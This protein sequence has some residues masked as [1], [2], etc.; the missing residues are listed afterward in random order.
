M[1]TG[2][3]LNEC[4]KLLLSAGAASVAVVV[5]ATTIRENSIF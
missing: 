2:S 5:A 3:T 4:A 1:T